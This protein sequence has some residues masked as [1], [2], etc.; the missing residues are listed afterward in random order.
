MEFLIVGISFCIAVSLV[1]TLELIKPA[2]DHIASVDPMN[3]LVQKK[4]FTYCIIFVV[5][6]FVAVLLVVPILSKNSADKFK[7]AFIEAGLKR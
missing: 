5:N 6:L 1:A 3:D 7:K 4:V 2:L